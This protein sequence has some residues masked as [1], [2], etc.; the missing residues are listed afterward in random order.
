MFW[1]I[2]MLPAAF[3]TD[4]ANDVL[5]FMMDAMDNG[6]CSISID[7]LDGKKSIGKSVVLCL[8]D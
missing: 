2:S 4:R 1:G 5:I 7:Q 8:R 3:R 6:Y